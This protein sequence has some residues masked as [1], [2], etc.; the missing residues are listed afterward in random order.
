MSSKTVISHRLPLDVPPTPGSEGS[1]G[2]VDV[3]GHVGHDLGAVLHV[4]CVAETRRV[5]G[6]PHRLLGHPDLESSVSGDGGRQL[7]AVRQQILTRYEVCGDAD[8][9]RLF[10]ANQATGQQDLR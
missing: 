9:L 7:D 10:A 6:L 3:A 5:E 2:A 8:P 4:D 1:E